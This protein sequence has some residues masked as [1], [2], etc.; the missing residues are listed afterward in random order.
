MTKEEKFNDNRRMARVARIRMRGVKRTG[1]SANDFHVI[2]AEGKY[3]WW[4]GTGRNRFRYEYK[5]RSGSTLRFR[6]INSKRAGSLSVIVSSI[7]AEIRFVSRKYSGKSV[8]YQ[9]G[10]IVFLLSG[11]SLLSS[12]YDVVQSF[13]ELSNLLS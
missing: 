8:D 11:G 10:K 1:D 4:H 9:R 6:L 5:C 3:R 13:L 12:V 2:F 7:I